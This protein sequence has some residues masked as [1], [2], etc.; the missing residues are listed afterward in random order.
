MNT[1]TQLKFSIAADEDAASHFTHETAAKLLPSMLP[2]PIHMVPMSTPAPTAEHRRSAAAHLSISKDSSGDYSID[3]A[4]GAWGSPHDVNFWATAESSV[5]GEGSMHKQASPLHPPISPPAAAATN[6]CRRYDEA[7]PSV[8]VRPPSPPLP[9]ASGGVPNAAQRGAS[10]PSSSY[11]CR[12]Y[13]QCHFGGPPHGAAEGSGSHMHS[14]ATANTTTTLSYGLGATFEMPPLCPT[15]AAAAARSAA[16]LWPPEA[17]AAGGGLCEG[18]ASTVGS[19]SAGCGMADFAGEGASEAAIA[20]VALLCTYGSSNSG[21]LAL[22]CSVEEREGDAGIINATAA[23]PTSATYFSGGCAAP[24]R[25]RDGASVTTSAARETNN[26]TNCGGW[27]AGLGFTG[28]LLGFGA[29]HLTPPLVAFQLSGDSHRSPSLCPIRHIHSAPSDCSATP[30]A[31]LLGRLPMVA[32]AIEDDNDAVPIEIPPLA[33]ELFGLAGSSPHDSLQHLPVAAANSAGTLQSSRAE[34]GAAPHAHALGQQ[35]PPG[36][37]GGEKKRK[38]QG[39]Q[40]RSGHCNGLRA[41]RGGFD[42]SAGNV[43]GTSLLTPFHG[44]TANADPAHSPAPTLRSLAPSQTTATDASLGMMGS[45]PV[46]PLSFSQSSHRPLD[47]H[48]AAD[49]KHIWMRSLT[50]T[51]TNVAILPQPQFPPFLQR[52]LSQSHLHSHSH[53]GLRYANNSR[54]RSDAAFVAAAAAADRSAT[55]AS[56]LTTYQQQ[57]QRHCA[58]AAARLLRQTEQEAAAEGPAAA[59]SGGGLPYHLNTS[60]HLHSSPSNHSTSACSKSPLSRQRRAMTFTKASAA[61]E[62]QRFV[63]GSILDWVHLPLTKPPFDEAPPRSPQLL[64]CDAPPDGEQQQQMGCAAVPK[65]TDRMVLAMSLSGVPNHNGKNNANGPDADA[66]EE[67]RKELFF[68]AAASDAESLESRAVTGAAQWLQSH[69]SASAQQQLGWAASPSGLGGLHHFSACEG[70]PIIGSGCSPFAPPNPSPLL[71][72]DTD[73]VV[74][75]ERRDGP[76]TSGVL[77]HMVASPSADRFACY[78]PNFGAIDSKGPLQ[79]NNAHSMPAAAAGP[80]ELPQLLMD[81]LEGNGG[82]ASTSLPAAHLSPSRTTAA[83]LND[84]LG[85]AKENDIAGGNDEKDNLSDKSLRAVGPTARQN[86]DTF[87][88]AASREENPDV[89]FLSSGNT[90]NLNTANTA[91]TNNNRTFLVPPARR[92][93]RGQE[94]DTAAQGGVACGDENTT[95]RTSKSTPPPPPSGHTPPTDVGGTCGSSPSA[96]AGTTNDAFTPPTGFTPPTLKK[97]T[98]PA[99]PEGPAA[100]GDEGGHTSA[101]PIA[102]PGVGLRRPPHVGAADECAALIPAAPIVARR[103]TSQLQREPS[104]FSSVPPQQR[105]PNNGREAARRPQSQRAT[106]V[107][108][109]GTA[110]G[111]A[112]AF[113]ETKLAETPDE[114]WKGNGE[115]ALDENTGLDG[116]GGITPSPPQGESLNPSPFAYQQQPQQ[117]QQLSPTPKVFLASP[118][119]FTYVYVDDDAGPPRPSCRAVVQ[120][121]CAAKPVEEA[122]P[123]LTGANLS[124]LQRQHFDAAP[125]CGFMRPSADGRHAANAVVEDPPIRDDPPTAEALL[126]ARVLEWTRSTAHA[127]I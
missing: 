26:S 123:L 57:H 87:V 107:D 64:A 74:L 93:V 79:D 90:A 81:R 10:I 69:R 1:C 30:H 60:P 34:C 111:D 120:T 71:A 37:G 126:R 77:G 41:A 99:M 114:C 105:T 92:A 3:V 119:P 125:S 11:L 127:S 116:P 31:P 118:S 65:G 58:A 96:A 40:D 112:A 8:H 49:S 27:A 108:E 101:A 9:R 39:N 2:T 32:A 33:F 17:A 18:D 86:T 50:P 117:Q 20:A 61:T 48:I 84:A 23:P 94:G 100:M 106:V 115:G 83:A 52:H 124:K 63:C 15:L 56:Q 80:F 72:L 82:M 70:R 16:H 6:D 38:R 78:L 47:S 51:P 35:W 88:C 43:H 75:A 95:V 109:N 55:F 36:S 59:E 12:T 98:P 22:L 21:S 85:V 122:L 53:V 7:L 5:R 76:E 67:Q 54:S 44:A 121:T 46:P 13:N 68:R 102:G 110:V 25:P 19:S 103:I 29:A 104:N 73:G 62:Q 45:L 28:G 89:F 91:A 4:A 66:C 113:C 42:L 24:T 14:S 97:F